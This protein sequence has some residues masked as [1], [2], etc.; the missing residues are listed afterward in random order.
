MCAAAPAPAPVPMDHTPVTLLRREDMVVLTFHFTNLSRTGGPDPQSLVVTDSALPA[1]VS[2]DFPPQTLLEEATSS[3]SDSARVKGGWLSGGSRLAFRVPAGTSV[4]FTTDGLLT[5]AGLPRDPA[6]TVLECVWGLPLGVLSGPAAWSNPTEPLT[7]PSGVTGLWHT[8]LG[9]PPGGSVTTAG[10]RVPL[11][12]GGSPRV[13]QPF[14]SSLNAAQRQEITGALARRPLL[15]GQLHLSAL[16]SSIDL[17]GDWS[18]LPGVGVTGYQH[19]AVTGRDVAVHVVERGYLLPFGFPVQIS[20]HTERRLDVGLFTVS[21]LTVLLPA[22]D[23]AGAH[24]L[25]HQGRAFPFTRVQLQGRLAAEVDESAEPIGTF[26][27]WVHAAEQTERLVFDI[28]CTDRRGHPLTLR[29]PLAYVRGDLGAQAL[30]AALTAYEQKSAGMTLPAAGNL[31]LAPVDGGAETTTVAVEGLTVGAEPAVGDGTPL[32]EAGRLPAYP[33]LL[34]VSS[35]LPPLQ[36]FRSRSS[37]APGAAAP[38][39]APDPVRLVLDQ[40]YVGS[41]LAAAGQVYAAVQQPPPPLPPV[42]FAP[43]VTDSGGVAALSQ[44]VSGLSA[45]AG[46]V[47][48]ALDKVK[49]GQFDPVSYFPKAGDPSGLLPPKLLGFLNLPDLVASTSTGDGKTV[50]RI[51]TEIVRDAADK[52]P[53]AVLTTMAWS[54]KVKTGTFFGILT[55]TDETRVDLRN[56][57][58]T[59]LDGTPPQVE[60]RGELSAFSL[61]FVGGIL[62][63]DFTRLAF[64]SKPGATPTLDA[65]VKKVG[66]GGDLEFLDRLRDYLPTPANGPH[67]S[68]DATG[69]EVGYSLGIPAIP[70]GV[71][72]MQN[73]TLSSSVTLP[74]DGKPVRAHF[75]LSSRDHPFTVSVSLLGGRGFFGITVDSGDIVE[76]EAQVEFGAAAA[77]NLGVASGSVSLT[78]GI[79]VKFQAQE[80]APHTLQARVSGFFRAVGALDVLGIISIS[81]EFYLALTYNTQTKVVHGT[82]LVVVRVRVAFFSKS[83]S[84]EVERDFGSGADPAFGDAFPDPLPWQA[85]CGAYAAMED[86]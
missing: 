81:V 78:A 58:R 86:T 7:G 2:V 65:K 33:R 9:L 77:L 25:P 18:G 6:G 10:N 1:S 37:A 66:F 39:P 12:S 4:P 29:A 8:R 82:A 52:P 15:A 35:R 11:G 75:A 57:T 38:P 27:F 28:L 59:P 26:G 83:V 45:T 42:G 60:C 55:T 61:S 67:F 70:A 48:G 24:G 53:K 51:V 46:L 84:L 32:V 80:T 76:L 69:I 40:T 22:L 5:W 20:T 73:L 21:R 3:A 36:A 68:V 50:P 43:P 79:Y 44:Q 47:G 30:A 19:H 23:Y 63:V 85:R 14:A 49:A 13:N 64:T 34:G 71:L 17:A 54:P 31:E 72:L 56:T 16:G 41:G 74:F 62:T